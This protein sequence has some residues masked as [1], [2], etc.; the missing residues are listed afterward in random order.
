MQER[1]ETF[2]VPKSIGPDSVNFEVELGVLFSRQIKETK[3]TS[4]NLLEFIA[5]Y[6]LL[7]DYTDKDFLVRDAT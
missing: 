7:L 2:I 5:G 1:S 3:V 4:S 6:F